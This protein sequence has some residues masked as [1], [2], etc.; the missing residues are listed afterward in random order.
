MIVRHVRC[1][2]DFHNIRLN[3]AMLPQN[4]VQLPRLN[5]NNTSRCQVV[6]NRIVVSHQFDSML[7]G[8]LVLIEAFVC[9]VLKPYRFRQKLVL[10]ML[11]SRLH[12]HF[13]VVIQPPF[14]NILNKFYHFLLDTKIRA[15]NKLQKILDLVEPPFHKMISLSLFYLKPS[16]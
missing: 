16:N 9:N 11:K 10:H 7:G 8:N 3:C 2:F 5:C 1:L 15:L 4:V 13:L 6:L 14:C 12:R